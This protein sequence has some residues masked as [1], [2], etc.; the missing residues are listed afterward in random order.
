MQNFFPQQESSNPNFQP[1][2]SD[3]HFVDSNN[4]LKDTKPKQQFLPNS[5]FSPNLQADLYNQQYY[6]AQQP[7]LQQ[8]QQQHSQQQQQVQYQQA[9]FQNQ[10]SQ[11]HAQQGQNQFINNPSKPFYPTPDGN[12]VN[13]GEYSQQ[14]SPQSQQYVDNNNIIYTNPAHYQSQSSNPYGQGFSQI[15]SGSYL[16]GE[17]PQPPQVVS[18]QHRP[19]N[20]LQHPNAQFQ[21]GGGSRP[22]YQSQ[23][24][25]HLQRPSDSGFGNEN[26][27]GF[28]QSIS[29]FFTNIGQSASEIFSSRPPVSYFIMSIFTIH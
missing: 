20:S 21:Y 1:S 5:K 8:Q 26:E 14:Y 2:P 13:F 29:N 16:V 15:V 24:N 7:Q 11:Q 4:Q 3:I 19:P 23:Q 28:M 22:V 25:Y 9:Q 18:P 10:F 17:R 27:S 12:E 6:G